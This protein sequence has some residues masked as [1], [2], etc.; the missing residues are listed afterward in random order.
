MQRLKPS[1]H[2]NT[3]LKDLHWLQYSNVSITN[4]ASSLT[5]VF[6]G[7]APLYMSDMLTACSNVPSL[8]RLRASS[9]SDYMVPRTR[10]MLVRWKIVRRRCSTD[11]EQIA[12]RT[13]NHWMYRNFQKITK[14]IF[15]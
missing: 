3:V 11:L 1:D 4:C 13:Q 10:L 6:R 5:I 9:S 12:L 8:A 2:V 14:N 7:C 15:I